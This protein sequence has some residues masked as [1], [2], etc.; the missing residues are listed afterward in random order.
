MRADNL[1]AGPTRHTAELSVMPRRNALG[2]LQM[3]ADNMPARPTRHPAELPPANLSAG[4]ALERQRVRSQRAD[5]YLPARA[6]LEWAP[7]RAVT[8]SS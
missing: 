8:A 3:R 6:T 1:P 4:R 7:M 5:A 2:R